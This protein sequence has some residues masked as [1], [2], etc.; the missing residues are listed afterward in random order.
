MV[1]GAIPGQN[2]PSI[3]T[4]KGKQR[5]IDAIPDV[6]FYR[7]PDRKLSF[8]RPEMNTISLLAD[9]NIG[10]QNIVA[11]PLGGGNTGGERT[12][13]MGPTQQPETPSEQYMREMK[14]E[15]PIP[16]PSPDAALKLGLIGGEA[17]AQDRN[18][19]NLHFGS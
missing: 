3:T 11:V 17:V 5:L 4:E 12:G 7:T 6:G 10:P 8:N 9:P 2:F 18:Q 16:T 15:A 1:S 19:G 14:T 13:L